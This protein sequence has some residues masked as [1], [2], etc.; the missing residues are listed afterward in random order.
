MTDSGLKPPK[1][2]DWLLK[3]TTRRQ[4]KFSILGDYEE[5]YSDLAS[6]QG[7]RKADTWY[8]LETMHSSIPF[9]CNKLFWRLDM[10][11]NYMKT[12]LRNI[13][14]QKVYSF[15][16][17]TGLAIGMACVILLVLYIRAELSIDDYHAYKDRI[18]RLCTHVTIGGTELRHA[19]S[20]ALSAGALKEEYPEVIEAVRFRYMGSP[21]AS[22]QTKRIPI[23]SSWYADPSVF[24]IFTW[25]LLKGDTEQALKAPY[26]IVIS[27]EVAESIFGDEDPLGK[28]IKMNDR[29]TYTVTGVMADV[30]ENSH[31]TP[32]VLCSFITLS[33]MGSA[34]RPM[35]TA[36]TSFNFNTYLL[37]AEGVDYRGFEE[38]IRYQLHEKAGD[39]LE[40][41][42]ATEFLFLHSLR[43]MYLRP[44][45]QSSGPAFYVTIF[46]AVAAFILLIAC[47]NFMNLSTAR[48]S[49]RALEV[50]MRKT[51]GAHRKRLIQQFLSEAWILSLIS[52]TVA[53]VFVW[54][55]LPSLRTMTGH[56]LPFRLFRDPQLFFGLLVLIIFT[57]FLAG[58][59]PAL[60]LS[61]FHP[62]C[63]LKGKMGSGTMSSRL[64]RVLV[65]IQFSIS[66]M[67]II[68]TLMIMRQLD[69]MRRR[70]P[71]FKKENI[72][73]L[74][75]EDDEARSQRL[76]LKDAF[77]SHPRIVSV[78]VSSNLPSWGC[79]T[80]D[81]LPEGF[82]REDIQLMD[83]IN[84]DEYFIPTMG[85][86]IIAGRNF[87]RDHMGDRNRSVI[88]NETAARR[89]AWDD[90]IG[91][92]I[93][94]YDIRAEQGF[95]PRTVIG[96]I[97]DFHIRS[98]MSTVD[99]MII[100]W[101][102]EFPFDYNKY[103]YMPV[104][105]QSPHPE[106]TLRFI[107]KT[108]KEILPDKTFDYFFMEE[109]Y[110]RQFRRMERARNIFSYFT[111]LAIFIACLG[112]L[113][114]ASFTAEK[115]TK[116]IGIR[117]VMGATERGM[118]A[119]LSREQLLLVFAANI[120]A[121]PAAYFWT[122]NWLE[123]FPYRIQMTLTP[124]IFTAALVLI[125]SFFTI[126]YQAIKAATAN[127]VEAL[128]YE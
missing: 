84:V 127:P 122:R 2:A 5:E 72:V 14:R 22:Y 11:N 125:I 67:L 58:S 98:M 19:S 121:W 16:N 90:P 103:W 32:D 31:M 109:A 71:G 7:R 9:L 110:D 29:T 33:T 15:I 82:A 94:V 38:K 51:L 112:L 115:R 77:R 108:W 54:I 64:R 3:H 35:L 97:R 117:K 24:R 119:L 23:Q 105:I 63:V 65:V 75:L 1:L 49:N 73:I 104:R 56:D 68:G 126:A 28:M 17:I 74:R 18:F 43:D 13:R 113:G 124:F 60:Y 116:E 57:G 88:I 21:T 8:W 100:N 52:M 102:P 6:R 47:V 41:K 61:A 50:G 4:E 83:D 66:I 20:N 70:D 76:V 10:F 25:P 99:P 128:R 81:K 36:W 27:E 39:E 106:E 45:N 107:E 92:I 89:Y 59:Y 123:G 93:Y 78:S 111:F 95:G 114:M 37:L 85:M 26:A 44:L 101:D 48:S 120:L 69:Y 30:P 53:L 40:A 91:K 87:S 12:A 79:A 46:S 42:G 55:A 80:N 118:V 62:I 34:T 86:E 96:M